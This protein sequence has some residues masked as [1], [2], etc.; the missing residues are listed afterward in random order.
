MP[1]ALVANKPWY[2]KAPEKRKHDAD[3]SMTDKRK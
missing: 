1:C 2:Y 3:F